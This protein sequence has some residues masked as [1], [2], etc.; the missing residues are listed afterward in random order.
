MSGTEKVLGSSLT[1]TFFFQTGNILFKKIAGQL[2]V[3]LSVFGLV[4]T[5]R[6]Y[7]FLR[8]FLKL[9]SFKCLIYAYIL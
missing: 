4:V 2:F 3:C 7:F 6:D 9:C 1:W 8:L 5:F